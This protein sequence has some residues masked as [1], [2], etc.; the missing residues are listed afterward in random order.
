MIRNRALWYRSEHVITF[1]IGYNYIYLW[2][3]LHIKW[4]GHKPE[5]PQGSNEIDFFLKCCFSY[6]DYA[7]ESKEP[8]ERGK[9]ADTAISRT[10]T[11]RRNMTHIHIKQKK[12]KTM[13]NADPTKK[14]RVNSDGLEGV[15]T[16]YPINKQLINL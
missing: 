8:D 7:K 12:P 9:S 15:R 16:C 2:Y 6:Q 13:N 10:Q 14:S 3:L 4:Y 5:A 11:R 1:I